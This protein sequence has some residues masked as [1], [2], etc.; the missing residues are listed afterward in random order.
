[1]THPEVY[2]MQKRIGR[3]FTWTAMLTRRGSTFAQD[4]A[5]Y[6]AERRAEGVD[7]W[8]QVTCRPLTFQMNMKDP[9]TFNMRP[10]FKALMDT[11]IEER[12]A[13]YGDP[14]WR[15]RAQDELEGAA[16]GAPRWAEM[17]IEESGDSSLVGRSI[18]DVAAERGVA[19]LDAMLDI[20]MAE[21][22]EPRFRSTLAND[23]FDTI[24][25]L[26][27]QDGVLMGLSDAGA[28]VSQLCDACMPTDLL[29]NWVREREV[30]TLEHAVNKLTGEP[31]GVYGFEGR[32]V[33]A[34]GNHADI[35]VF[36]PDTVAPGPVRRIRDFPADGER[37]V[38]DR[39]GGMRHVIV[40]GTPIRVDGEADTDGL[41]SKPG[42][43]LRG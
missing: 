10:I 9:F 34:V 22:L 28:H 43:I 11:P 29:G 24:T 36:D 16:M 5:A 23:D 30:L 42:H 32:G 41:A 6:S 35:T 13:A 37:L 15:E 14:S 39:P 8:P 40:N 4:M 1:V 21:N 20:S 3:P 31:A 17:T 19:P 25:D 33:L 38:A 18:A 12:L 27:Q 7:V 26:L 2:D